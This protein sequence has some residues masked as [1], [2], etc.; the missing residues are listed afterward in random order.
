M[1]VWERDYTEDELVEAELA[2]FA[3]DNYG[4]VWHM[5]EYPEEYENGEFDK[6][7]GWL[8]G[9]KGASAGIAMR[10]EPRLKT[11]S[12]AQGYAPPPSTGSTVGGCMRLARK[13]A[14]PSIATMMF[15]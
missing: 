8:A 11:P 15:L 2:F 3:Q 4:N 14:C 12:Y 13:P 9:S 6:A 1:V 10:A 5:G 7:P